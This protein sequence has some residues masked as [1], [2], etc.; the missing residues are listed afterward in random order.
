M[1][2]HTGYQSPFGML[3]L[4]SNG[5]ELTELSFGTNLVAS[6]ETCDIL[7]QTTKQ[8]DEYFAGM[9]T[10]FEIPLSLAGTDFQVKVWKALLTIP[11]GETRS[12]SD[13]AMQIGNSKATRAVGMANNKNKIAIIIPCHRVIGKNGKLV[14]YA[15][16]L[17]FKQKL[18]ELEQ[19]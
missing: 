1:F 12:Y 4:S 2:Y 16:G 15:G 10:Q 13:L 8:L 17:D 18:L 3:K 14:G 7:K 9:R 6:D 5:Q 19:R 11:F